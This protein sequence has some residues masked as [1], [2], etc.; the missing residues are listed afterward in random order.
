MAMHPLLG[1]V[2]E[3]NTRLFEW[4]AFHLGGP[5]GK[6]LSLAIRRLGAAVTNG[7]IALSPAR[8]ASGG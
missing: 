6:R 3:L 1:T 2:A 7:L 5:S 4:L 8:S